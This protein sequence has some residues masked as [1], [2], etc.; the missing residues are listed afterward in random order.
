MIPIK[1]AKEVCYW[2]ETKRIFFKKSYE[3]KLVKG[4]QMQ[5]SR[6]RRGE[7]EKKPICY[8]QSLILQNHA[9]TFHIGFA[10]VGILGSRWLLELESLPGLTSQDLESR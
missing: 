4:P 9:F 2:F 5:Q 3:Y 8:F 6:A 1:N 7:C 10:K